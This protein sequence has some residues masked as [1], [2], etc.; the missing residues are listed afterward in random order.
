MHKSNR[1]SSRTILIMFIFAI[2]VIPSYFFLRT[3]TTPIINKNAEKSE[4]E[5]LLSK[6]IQNNYPS[7][8]KEV[9]KLYSR[10]TK[11]LYN[12]KHDDDTIKKLAD[13]LRVLMDDE[14]LE[15]NQYEE[16]LLDIKV[17]ITGYRK[18]N[19]TFMSYMIEGNNSVEYWESEDKEY[20]SI[21]ASYTL[22][23]KNDYT[24]VYEEFILRKDSEGKWKIL[25]W[26]VTD[27]TDI[28]SES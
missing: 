20:A 5:I 4:L 27:K 3:R 19:R 16:Y 14:L 15:Q 28:D 22:K 7:T 17:E 9:I 26:E 8:P 23:E 2:I 21:V 12:E 24:K 18:S 1:S 11:N 6:D 25:G 13:Q 10:I